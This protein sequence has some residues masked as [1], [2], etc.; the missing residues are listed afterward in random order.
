MTLPIT[1]SSIVVS[2]DNHIMS[3]RVNQQFRAVGTYS[4]E[5][6]KD[7]TLDCTWTSTNPYVATV[8]SSGLVY[9]L[10]EGHTEIRA[11]LGSISGGLRIKVFRGFFPSIDSVD[12]AA[13]MMFTLY[14]Y[15]P[16]GKEISVPGLGTVTIPVSV[17][18]WDDER[19]YISKYLKSI[20]VKFT[21]S[22]R[23][24]DRF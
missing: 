1:L 5:T 20:G 9:T 24:F 19:R 12:N 11:A 18:M 3:L 10:E 2:A 4:N 21:I 17:L 8:N 23:P 22:H 14:M 6:T 7:L 13:R 16:A 15:S